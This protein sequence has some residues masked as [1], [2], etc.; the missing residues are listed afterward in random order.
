VE[1]LPQPLLVI[2]PDNLTAI[3]ELAR[4]GTA[5]IY[6]TILSADRSRIFALTSEGIKAYQTDSMERL[7]WFTDL[8]PLMDGWGIP[9][10]G[11]SSSSDGQRFSILTSKNQAQVYDLEDGLVYSATLPISYWEPWAALSTDGQSLAMK[12]VGAEEDDMHWQLVDID[13]G[14][15][16]ANGIGMNARFSPAGTYLV[17][18]AS[19]TL[20]IYR[21]TDWQEQTQIGLRAG[22]VTASDWSF[23]PD[24]RYLAVVMPNGITVWEV[25]TRQRVRQFNPITSPEAE[26]IQAFFSED[27]S[28]MAVLERFDRQSRL[29]VWNIADGSLVS[30]QT[31]QEAGI[32]NYNQVLLEMDGLHGYSLP[33]ESDGSDYQSPQGT[34]WQKAFDLTDT[35][36]Y[37]SDISGWDDQT[38]QPVYTACTFAFLPAADPLCQEAIGVLGVTTDSLGH[39]FSLWQADGSDVL[40]YRGLEASGTLLL[41]FSTGGYSIKPLGVSPDQRLLVYSLGEGDSTLQVRE[42]S[43]NRTLF[44]EDTTGRIQDVVFSADGSRLAAN[45]TGPSNSHPQVLVYDAVQNA[46]LYR[47]PAQEMMSGSSAVLSPDGERLAYRFERWDAL[48]WFGIQ[49]WDPL[50]QRQLA[51][52]E[53][54]EE[55]LGRPL[56]FSL[57]GRLL[58][59]ADR[60]GTVFLLDAETGTML[61]QWRAHT[62]EVLNLAFSPDGTLL[63]TSGTDGFLRLWGIYP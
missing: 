45:I 26:V 48:R 62:D 41:T 38:F 36:L 33:H 8:N 61:H 21:T 50:H 9:L 24:D 29:L 55:Q 31:T 58:A 47:L 51:E 13:N 19:D 59:T 7:A 40:L 57:D 35:S 17:G 53:G 49:V 10:W 14:G 23:S 6:G 2:S 5:R 15:V 30:N 34:G 32:Y 22:G 20:Y 39:F 43:T 46:V 52:W 42:I 54:F 1:D 27:S 25:Q 12:Q 3:S 37:V 18:N 56:A 63:A 4:Y 16:I 28:Q 60:S 44:T 11:F